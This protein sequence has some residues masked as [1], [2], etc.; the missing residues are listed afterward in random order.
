MWGNVELLRNVFCDDVIKNR[1]FTPG[2]LGVGC[3]PKK[4]W[5]FLKKI[6]KKY[7]KFFLNLFLDILFYKI[8]FFLNIKGTT[9]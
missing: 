9:R 3:P 2:P 1:F 7:F 5:I 6:L 4:I 8:F